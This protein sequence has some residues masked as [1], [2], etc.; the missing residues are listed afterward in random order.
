[1]TLSVWMTPTPFEAMRDQTNAIHNI[2]CR[3]DKYLP[4]YGI[5]LVEQPD[6]AALYAGHA[7]QG[8]QGAV[9]VA[10]YHGIYN[11]AQGSDNFA[12]N[13]EVIKNL[14]SARIVI[15]PSE[16]IS[17]VIKR[18][19]HIDPR[20]I[21]WGVDTDEWQPVKEHGNYVIWNKARVD[22]ITNP[23]PMLELAARAN[24]VLFLTTFGQGTPNVRTVGRQIYPVMKEMVRNAA[25]YLSLNVETWGLGLA[26]AL[27]A[28][29]PILGF[30][31]GN[32][33]DLIEHG[34]HGFMAEP[35]DMN[36]LYEG[37]QY[38]LKHRDRLGANARERAKDFPW[39][40]TAKRFSEVF[41]DA[42]T[43]KQDIRPHRIDESLYKV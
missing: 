37:L 19:M 2:V 35:G 16:W 18:D 38:C 25:V 32:L 1:M 20:I 14:K 7:G 6:N 26:E 24:D 21:P 13:A 27:A 30:R 36:G 40:N 39:Q 17:M 5:Q 43:M 22:N 12:V 28:G 31:Q 42:W 15:A 34:V 8:S 29:I 4:D 3:M 23:Q 41:H 9:D 33:P 11:T 10:I